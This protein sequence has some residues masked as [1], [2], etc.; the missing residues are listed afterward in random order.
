M[1]V[2]GTPLPTWAAATASGDPA[3]TTAGEDHPTLSLVMPTIAWEGTFPRCADAALKS[4]RPGDQALFVFDGSPPEPPAWLLATGACLLCTSHRQGPAAARNL[5]ARQARQ[6][7]LVFVDADVEIHSDAL[8]RLRAHF[9]ADPG[10]SAVFGSYDNQPAAPGL[11]SRYRNLLHHHTHSSHPGQASTFWAGLGAI[12]REAFLAVGG[13]DAVAYPRPSIEDIE[14]GLRLSDGGARL[15]LDPAIQG[16]HHK[17][18]TLRSMLTTDIRQRAI[19]WSRLLL[20]R[21]QGSSVLNLD[22]RARLSTLLSLALALSSG[23]LAWWPW[24]WPLP[25]LALAGVLLLN[26]RFH[27]LCLRQGGPALALVAISL[28]VI[29]FL[30]SALTFAVVLLQHHLCAIRAAAARMW[31]KP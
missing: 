17:L 10:L 13:F 26:H 9:C 14:L 1:P 22:W 29:Y 20:Q 11:V 27:R 3:G 12:R 24:I 31:M 21:H 16:T 2:S 7:I 19:P 4:L 5:G 18:W 8:D 6:P 30:Y 28:Q 15:L 23:A 25:L